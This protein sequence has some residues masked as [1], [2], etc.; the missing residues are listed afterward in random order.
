MREEERSGAVDLEI[1]SY[2]EEWTQDWPLGDT[3]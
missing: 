1:K 2:E 3:Q